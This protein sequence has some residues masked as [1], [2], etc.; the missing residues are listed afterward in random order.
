MHPKPVPPSTQSVWFRL[1]FAWMSF[2]QKMGNAVALAALVLLFFVVLTPL[3]LLRR[4]TGSDPLRRKFERLKNT[5]H[6][7]YT[8]SEYDHQHW[9]RMY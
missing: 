1:K 8:Q 2:G 6:S 3:A 5:K 7:Y 9:T 4:I